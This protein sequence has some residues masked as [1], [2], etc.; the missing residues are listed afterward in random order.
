MYDSLV[1]DVIVVDMNL[2]IDLFYSQCLFFKKKLLFFGVFP[3]IKTGMY[4]LA[5][6]LFRLLGFQRK[7]FQRMNVL[8]FIYG[9][10]ENLH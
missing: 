1:L 6:G 4:T 5:V 3:P 10:F 2:R 8:K 9:L 7:C